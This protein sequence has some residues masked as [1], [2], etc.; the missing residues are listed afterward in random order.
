M[1]SNAVAEFGRVDILVNNAGVLLHRLILDMTE[2]EWD[3]VIDID[4]KG[5][6]LC[7][8]AAAREM[9]K[10]KSGKIHP[11]IKLFRKEAYPGGSSIFC[12]KSR[13]A[14]F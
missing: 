11:Y 7:S 13:C 9:V 6:F 1:V 8:Q 4:M 3:R 12:S 5:C 14:G 2:E 10:R